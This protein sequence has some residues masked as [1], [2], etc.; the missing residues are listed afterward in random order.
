MKELTSVTI[1]FNG[2]DLHLNV[3]RSTTCDDVIKMVN[4]KTASTNKMKCFGIF[5]SAFGVQ[6]MLS[7]QTK[8]VKQMRSWGANSKNFSLELKEVDM[9]KSKMASLSR[10]RTKLQRLR[11]LLM[12]HEL[13]TDQ[14]FATYLVDNMNSNQVDKKKK[15]YNKNITV[16][17]KSV[18]SAQ[19]NDLK[20]EKLLKKFLNESIDHKK[21]CDTEMDLP[22]RT[23][24]DGSDE[25]DSDLHLSERRG[26]DGEEM[27]AS[28]LNTGFITLNHIAN[29]TITEME[30]DLND[31]VIYDDDETFSHEDEKTFEE[32]SDYESVDELEKNVVESFS[33]TRNTDLTNI[34]RMFSND[35]LNAKIT[36][37]DLLESF[38]NTF[39]KDDDSDEGMNSAESDFE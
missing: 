19:P 1:S 4:T 7:G 31:C 25:L 38:M 24:G 12:K 17:E 27:N 5:E 30:D 20:R 8:V 16:L 36:D 22:A 3:S 11:S 6:R 23:L 13:K 9:V 33:E 35:D 21:L 29:N 37:D 14:K 32:D 10:A 28:F 39:V 2:E 18:E 34:K 26:G 15:L